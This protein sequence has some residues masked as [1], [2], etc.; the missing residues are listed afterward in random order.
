M[1]FQECATKERNEN[2]RWTTVVILFWVVMVAA[3]SGVNA[4]EFFRA[5]DLNAQLQA[6][7]AATEKSRAIMERMVKE[8]PGWR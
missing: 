7:I 2:Q 4:Y 6:S 5:R 1:K 8:A 3:W